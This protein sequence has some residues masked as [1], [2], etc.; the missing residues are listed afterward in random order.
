MKQGGTA[1]AVPRKGCYMD[2][3]RVYND[4]KYD[5]GLILQSGMERV[6]HPGTFTP[7]TQDEIEYCASLAPALFAGEKQLRLENR[8][9]AVQ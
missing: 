2:K 7:M 9:L 1:R 3:I 8:D 5:I 4:R 6:I